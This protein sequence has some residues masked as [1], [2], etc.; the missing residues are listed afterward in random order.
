MA[1]AAGDV[2]KLVV[3]QL[4]RLRV[5]QVEIR[6]CALLGQLH[7]VFLGKRHQ[8]F[9]GLCGFCLFNKF[10]CKFVFHKNLPV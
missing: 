3:A 1:A 4:A 8:L 5:E 9:R 10:G 6:F 7:A 2:V